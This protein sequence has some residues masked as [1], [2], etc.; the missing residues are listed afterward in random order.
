MAGPYNWTAI[1]E[2]VDLDREVSNH[3]EGIITDQVS[4][5]S[6]CLSGESQDDFHMCLSNTAFE[7]IAQARQ[8]CQRQANLCPPHEEEENSNDTNVSLRT[9]LRQFELMIRQ[10][11]H[12]SNKGPHPLLL[13]TN[14]PITGINDHSLTGRQ[15]EKPHINPRAQ[16]TELQGITASLRPT[17]PNTNYRMSMMPP[18]AQW[19]RSSLAPPQM[20]AAHQTRPNYLDS[21][22]NSPIGCSIKPQPAVTST[23]APT[24]A[25]QTGPVANTIPLMV[26]APLNNQQQWQQLNNAANPTVDPTDEHIL[27]MIK[28][29]EETAQ[30][31]P[32]LSLNVSKMGIK[33]DIPSY[34]CNRMLAAFEDF[35]KDT[36]Q[37]FLIYQL[38]P[39]KF[40]WQH[41]CILGTTLKSDVNKWFKQTIDTQ[42]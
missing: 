32:I 11:S 29:A 38:M 10:T 30:N 28:H 16:H 26:L 14:T 19:L 35:I 6:C 40:E 25:R 27:S 1:L 34:V 4:T 20:N 37:Y 13:N 41:I 3:V 7:W 17:M 31:E 22:H 8:A 21:R 36:L 24:I 23:M 18:L 2:R 42:D 39:P 9:R 12:W 15:E 5:L 33:V